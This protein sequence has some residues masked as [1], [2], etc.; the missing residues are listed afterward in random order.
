MELFQTMNKRTI[1]CCF[2]FSLSLFSDGQ[3]VDNYHPHF[4][5][6]WGY[7]KEWYSPSTIHI[8]QPSLGNNYDLKDVTGNDRI[9][10][11]K[12]FTHEPTIPQYNYRIGFYRRKNAS[13]GFELNFDHTK[14]QLTPGQ[15]A[16]IVGTI[17]NRHVDTNM[18][19]VDDYYFWKLNNGANFFCFNIIKRFFVTG[20]MNGKIR[21]YLVTKAGIGPVV[22]HIE[23]TLMGKSNTPHF[24]L[25]GWNMGLELNYRCE[26][27]RHF[28]VDI[29]QKLDYARYSGLI[30]YEG[31]GK[32]S[33]SCYEVMATLGVMIPIRRIIRDM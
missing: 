4:Y 20:T 6:A 27:L 3:E 33:F 15:N 13:V 18:I 30:I 10:W 26:F 31:K 11:D 17:N 23:N 28:Y 16:H 9:G 1:L 22:P 29:A 21:T 32:Q 7:N 5:F 24:Q 25:G 14:Y 19:I 8:D 12:L 2:L